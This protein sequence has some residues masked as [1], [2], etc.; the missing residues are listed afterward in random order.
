VKITKTGED[1]LVLGRWEDDGGSWVTVALDRDGQAMVMSFPEDDLE[2]IGHD[3][4]EP[5][6]TGTGE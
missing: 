6:T 5:G 3:H 4:P 1:A 2:E